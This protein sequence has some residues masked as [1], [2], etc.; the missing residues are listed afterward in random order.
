MK[1]IKNFV[2]SEIRTGDIWRDRYGKKIT[3][4]SVI[5]AR[6]FYDREG[7]EHICS[8]PRFQFIETF[9]PD[10]SVK[11][12]L[13]TIALNPRKALEEIREKIRT[14]KEEKK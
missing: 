9:T 1:N 6:V 5:P 4:R 2:C 14:S 11:K 3:I 10:A 13:Y 12:S 8:M 7:Y